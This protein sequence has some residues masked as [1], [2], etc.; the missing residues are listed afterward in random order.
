M[1]LSFHAKAIVASWHSEV[2]AALSNVRIRGQILH[3]FF[4]QTSAGKGFEATSSLVLSILSV[5]RRIE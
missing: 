4:S 5:I 2:P 3:L 1:L